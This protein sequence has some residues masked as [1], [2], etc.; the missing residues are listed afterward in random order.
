MAVSI[1]ISE[2][3]QEIWD[4]DTNPGLTGMSTTSFAGF[5]RE[6]TYCQGAIVSN[7]TVQGYLAVT[8][9]NALQR[10]LYIWMLPRG[11]MDTL[12]NGGVR[13]IAGDGTNRIAYYVGGSNYTTP[14]TVNGWFCYVLDGNNPPTGYAT[15]AGSEASLNWSAITQVG[16]GFKT[17]AKSLGNVENCFFDIARHGTGLNIKGGTSGDPGTWAEIAAD[18]ASTAAGKAYGVV[19]EFQPGVY[20]VQGNINIGDSSG[21]TST[22]FQDSNANVVLMDTGIESMS[23]TVVG[24][25]TGTNEFIDGVAVGSGDTKRGRAGSTFLNAGVLATVDF[26]DA[27]VDTLE[28]FGTKFQAIDQGVSFGTDTSHDLAGVTFQACGQVDLGS[29]IARNVTFAETVSTN[30]ALL[31]NSNINVA[32]SNFIANTTAAAIEHDTAGEYDYTGLI[33]SSNTYDVNFSAASG[34]LIINNLGTSNASSYTI[35]GG[36]SSVEFVTQR[37]LTLDGLASGSEVRIMDMSKNELDGVESSGTSFEYN[38]NYS[39]G[40]YIYYRV[41]HMNY[42]DIWQR[43][44]LTDSNQ[45]IPISQQWDRN[46]YNPS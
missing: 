9:F 15:L 31:W 10:K 21:T 28:L 2:T 3:M 46:Y 30:A 37:T 11:E 25:G 24:N 32:Y 29:V 22:Y 13:M 44:L 7:T 34:D 38:Y 14:F 39:P 12:A 26:S 45:T 40:T 35:T 33:F 43:Y 42:V 36:G 16:L 20:G 6:G 1:T 23:V 19:M 4:A 18:D 8:S 27:N 17:L 5:Q 41:L